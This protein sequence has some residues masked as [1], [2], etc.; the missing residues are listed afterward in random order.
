MRRWP[1]AFWAI[2]ALAAVV[3]SDVALAQSAA[4]PALRG[5]LLAL[6]E[7]GAVARFTA[8]GGA[9]AARADGGSLALLGERTAAWAVAPAPAPRARGDRL[10]GLPPNSVGEAA[11][12]CFDP[13]SRSWRAC[14]FLDGQ[15]LLLPSPPGAVASSAIDADPA[16]PVAGS[17]V[18]GRGAH[19]RSVAALW[20]N[21]QPLLLHAD[22]P[23]CAMGANAAGDAAG[24]VETAAGRVAVLW[25]AGR[26]APVDL[27]TLLDPALGWRLLEAH[28]VRSDGAVLALA[29]TP[30][31]LAI[32]LLEPTTIDPDANSDG[33]VDGR[34]L[35][36]ALQQGD[37]DAAARRRWLA[38]FE[39]QAPR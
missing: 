36:L 1:Y 10:G 32:V 20:R 12:A 35:S 24:W 8:G 19:Q 31:G 7:P 2:S 26:S 13:Q 3:F 11:G 33:V 14:L 39:A 37:L 23:S 38:A 18:L 4:Q 15:R 16:G 22:G 28:D 27:N 9:V 21:N 29:R 5:R 25:R 6:V 34:D 30:Q 17:I